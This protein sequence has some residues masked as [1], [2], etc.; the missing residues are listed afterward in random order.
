MKKK[1][2]TATVLILSV[3]FCSSCG[4]RESNLTYTSINEEFISE[5]VG[6]EGSLTW[7]VNSVQWSDQVG[8]FGIAP[9][10]LENFDG[11]FYT[12]N[13]NSVFYD[14][15]DYVDTVSGQL[16]D[17][18]LFVLINLTVTNTDAVGKIV[19][20]NDNGYRDDSWYC[21]PIQ[22][23]SLCDVSEQGDNG[24]LNYNAIWYDGIPEFD[25]DAMGTNGNNYFILRPGERL[26][27]RL[28][29]IIGSDDGD[30]SHVCLTDHGG[31]YYAEKTGHKANYIQLNIP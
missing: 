7:K 25:S 12:D 6:G 19:P 14:W 5:V 2:I 9:S 20:E 3:L 31:S 15:P 21:F 26:T 17:D 11:V 27:Y 28:G 13:G 8:E 22:R 16:A 10:E 23:L 29:F 30:F 4:S 24:F 18:L 1:F